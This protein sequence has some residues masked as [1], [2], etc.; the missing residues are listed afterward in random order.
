M[1]LKNNKHLNIRRS[2]ERS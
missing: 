2:L 1:L